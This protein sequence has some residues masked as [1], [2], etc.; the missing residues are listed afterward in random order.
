MCMA[1]LFHM[2]RKRLRAVVLLNIQG[3]RTSRK[4]ILRVDK[5]RNQTIEDIA[6]LSGLN[7]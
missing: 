5:A 4:G 3:K 7:F 2:D 1:D 6:F